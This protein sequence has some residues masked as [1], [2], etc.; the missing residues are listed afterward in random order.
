MKDK[1]LK[2][3]TRISKKNKI[4]RLPMLAVIFLF[5]AFCHLMQYIFNQKWRLCGTACAVLV[6]LLSSSFA[7]PVLLDIDYENGGEST[8]Y[9]SNLESMMQSGDLDDIVLDDGELGDGFED[10]ESYDVAEM[11]TYSMDEILQA[12]EGYLNGDDE[13]AAGND[14][15]E[16][17]ENITFSADDWRLVLINKQHPIPEGYTFTLTTITGSMQCDE[18]ILTDLLMMLQAAKEDNVSLIICSPYRDLSKQEYLFERKIKAYMNRGLTYMD[19]Y[20]MTSQA[21]TVPGASEHQIGLSLDIYTASYLVLDDGF[22]ETI[23]GKWLVEHG[24]E[25]GFILRYP[26]EKEYITGIGYEPWHFRYVGKDAAKIMKEE[27]LTLEEFWDL[28]VE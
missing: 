7:L 2:K 25:Y 12:N 9:E 1:I 27:D 16:A 13:P 19:A 26:Q 24:W 18:R 4:L 28:Y 23:A 11:D 21:V 22:G 14:V 5:L 3:L 6:F 15:S 17:K 20:K 10:Y 8:I